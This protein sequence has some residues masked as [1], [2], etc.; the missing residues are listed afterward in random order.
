MT[1]AP[2]LTRARLVRDLRALGIGT[3]EVLLVHASLRK[4]GWV[5]GGAAT[6]VAALR[7]VLGGRGT[8]V[9]PTQTA[10]NSDTSRLHLARIAG[11]TGDEVDRFRAAMPAFDVTATSATSMGRIA[12]AVRRTPGAV[13]SSHPQTSFAALGPLAVPL[14][15]GHAPDCHLGERSPVARLYDAGARLLLLGVDYGACCAFH[16]GEYRY[17]ESPPTQAYGCVIAADRG[18]RWWWYHD[19]VLD[20]SDFR[21]LGA[22]FEATGQVTGGSVGAAACR[23]AGVPAAVDFA[24]RW[25][26]ENRRLPGAPAPGLPAPGLGARHQ[27]ARS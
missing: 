15:A 16:L 18:A 5:Q 20:D 10:D 7:E 25:L 1:G 19:V 26:A 3:G 14:M 24:T 17:T 12:E 21:R 6:V 23:L 27:P 22:A 8:L 2:G 9:V 13:R 4:V 11:M